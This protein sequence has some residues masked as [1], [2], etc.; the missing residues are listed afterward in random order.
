MHLIGRD[1]EAAHIADSVDARMASMPSNGGASDPR[2]GTETF[3]AIAHLWNG[4]SA[5]ARTVLAARRADTSPD[6][7]GTRHLQAASI[8]AQLGLRAEAIALLREVVPNRLTFQG[9][10]PESVL[11]LPL[12]DEP[13]FK[14]LIAP[15]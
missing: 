10:W 8:A 13:D 3:R 4:D 1:A 5:L 14:A 9:G 2:A 7:R 12:R 15:R 11:L 6:P